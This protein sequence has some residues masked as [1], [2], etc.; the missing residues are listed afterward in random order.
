M[1]AL[2]AAEGLVRRY[3][4]RT[5]VDVPRLAI[6]RGEIVA[7]LGPNG[8][9]KSTLFRLLLLLER[10]DAGRVLLEGREVAHGDG[11]ARRRMAGVFQRPHLFSGR[12]EENLRF[13][14]RAT[15]VPRSEW[16]ARVDRAAGELGISA[17]LSARVERLSGGEAQRVALARALVLDPD[18]LLLDEPTASLDTTI[19][20][21]FR[22]EL[23]S[24]L[25]ERAGAVILITHDAAD[26]FDLADRVAVME[27]GRI[28]QVGTPEDLTTDPATPFVA[29]FTGAEL[30]LDGAV[31]DVEEGTVRVR[32]GEALL[33]ARA[34]E[35]ALAPGTAVHV[36]YR[37][38]DVTLA[39]PGAQDVSAR[40]R[41]RM[42]V[43]TVTPVGGLIRVRLDGPVTLA[44]L[45]T[46]DSAER[47]GVVPGAEITAL[48]K[49]TALHVYPAGHR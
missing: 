2:L 29:A 3:G 32:A 27:G 5:V 25:R 47:L 36:R 31:E 24:V 34:P 16:P 33:V 35:A 43:R 7:I 28:V 14:L 10:P 46:R 49:T 30:L 15:G 48:L 12:V 1:T 42:R 44:A 9:G 37:P 19:R 17:L 23:G 45:M 39:P 26:A 21:R 6:R 22:E 41:L 4:G 11:A 20:R 40:N 13:G 38:E 8:A 18:V